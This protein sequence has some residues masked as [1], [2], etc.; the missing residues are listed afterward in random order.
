MPDRISV[1]TFADHCSTGP[2]PK[3][4][5]GAAVLPVNDLRKILSS[6]HQCIFLFFQ[7]GACTLQCIQKTTACRIEIKCHDRLI[8]HSHSFLHQTRCGRHWLIS[9]Q[10]GNDQQPNICFVHTGIQKRFFPGFCRQHAC[11]F[12]YCNIS[13]MNAGTLHD[14]FITGIDCLFQFMIA[15]MCSGM[16]VSAS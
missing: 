2:I 6:D 1:C 4:D 8:H 11:R 12:I 7:H 5:T 13:C 10:R 9:R 14:P 3:Q 16:C 15:H